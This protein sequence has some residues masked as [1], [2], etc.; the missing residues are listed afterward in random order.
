T[1]RLYKVAPSDFDGYRDYVRDQ[2]NHDHPPRPPGALVFDEV[3]KTGGA[4]NQLA[5]TSIDLAPVLGKGGLG[6][7]MAIVEP[8]PWRESGPPPRMISWVQAT[9]LAVDAHVDADDVVAFAT[10]LDT[11]KPAGGV[12][13]ELRPSGARAQT[14]DKGTA[15]IPLAEPGAKGAHYLIARRGD[16][17]AFVD[18]GNYWNESGSWN[19]RAHPLQL[20]WYVVDDR[21]LY[22]PGEEV[23]LKGWLRTFDPG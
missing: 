6:H 21:Q 7:A 5:E 1:V 20:A 8:S 3:V 4:P 15:T 9:R 2:W 19:K 12:A 14:D 23:T 18:D 22:K 17:V 10:E 16:D 13:L 11:G